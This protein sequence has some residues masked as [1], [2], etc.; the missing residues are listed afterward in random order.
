MKIQKLGIISLTTA[1]LLVLSTIST[2]IPNS[3]YAKT[4]D[5]SNAQTSAADND[6][7]AIADTPSAIQ[8]QINTNCLND[9]DMVQDS[10]GASIA[11]TPFNA[12]PN[13]AL[14]LDPNF[15]DE[16]GGPTQPPT[17]TCVE[18]FTESL[19]PEQISRLQDFYL[20]KIFD[21]C[22]YWDDNRQIIRIDLDYLR[23]NMSTI[24][25]V[26]QTTVNRI[27][28]CIERVFGL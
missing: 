27:I 26:D 15:G 18:C 22:Q 13:Q 19:T 17:H 20:E 25:G 16:N 6:C 28:D 8:Q 23:E 5:N 21:I 7:P 2:I 3:G 10:D 9:T 4:Y 24:V 11:S 14:E 1:F 12:A